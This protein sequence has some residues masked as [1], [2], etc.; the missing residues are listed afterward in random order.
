MRTATLN[1]KQ[2]DNINKNNK[3]NK[4]LYQKRNHCFDKY[5]S[6]QN[7]LDSNSLHLRID[8]ERWHTTHNR[9]RWINGDDTLRREREQTVLLPLMVSFV[10]GHQTWYILNSE[11]GK[12]PEMLAF[13]IPSATSDRIGQ[14]DNDEIMNDTQD[15]T[16]KRTKKWFYTL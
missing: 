13:R 8:T 9:S 12:M 4:N 3:N 7:A 15:T 5:L 10:A 16:N 1:T 6:M 14:T 11:I 2:N